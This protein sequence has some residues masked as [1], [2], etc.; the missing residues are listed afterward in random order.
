[1]DSETS[2]NNY[3]HTRNR[4]AKRHNKPELKQIQLY[5][6]RRWKGTRTYKLTRS[7]LHTQQVSGHS[8]NDV[9]ATLKY[10]TLEDDLGSWI[11]IKAI[12]DEEKAECISND[13]P[14][15][16]NDNGIFWFKKPA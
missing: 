9:R 5:D 4:I 1:M 7:I 6:F 14:L 10:I 16:A 12:T 8:Q 3:R 15:V 11:P 13:Y 2:A